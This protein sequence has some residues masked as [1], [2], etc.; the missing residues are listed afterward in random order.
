[1][2]FFV[3]AFMDNKTLVIDD[4]LPSSTV[5]DLKNIILAR[6]YIRVDQQRLIFDGHQL[7]DDAATL[8]MEKIVDGSTVHLV[9]R[10]L[11]GGDE[12]VGR[13]EWRGWKVHS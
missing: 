11:G 6:L 5:L 7:K 3:K 2:E 10:L 4:L 1:M 9:M 13:R 8:D 12:E